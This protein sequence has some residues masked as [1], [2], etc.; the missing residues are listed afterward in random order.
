[1]SSQC[2]IDALAYLLTTVL[3]FTGSLY[4]TGRERPTV[5]TGTVGPTYLPTYRYVNSIPYILEGIRTQ[6]PKFVL[7]RRRQGHYDRF[8]LRSSKS[9]PYFLCKD[10]RGVDTT[11]R[12]TEACRL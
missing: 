1:M 9:R 11:I 6:F 5:R 8:W 3:Y 7:V 10:P 2:P 4:C 12:N